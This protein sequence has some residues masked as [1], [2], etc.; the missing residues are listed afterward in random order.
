[1]HVM[2]ETST[3]IQ[4]AC[5]EYSILMVTGSD[6]KETPYFLFYSNFHI[7]LKSTKYRFLV[8]LNMI[9]FSLEF[10]PMKASPV[11]RVDFEPLSAVRYK[12]ERYEARA[13]TLDYRAYRAYCLTR[14]YCTNSNKGF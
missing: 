3:C 9:F 2:G 8:T 13:K 5:S 7:G 12:Q 14:I 6:I 4:A 11:A 1:M 10:L